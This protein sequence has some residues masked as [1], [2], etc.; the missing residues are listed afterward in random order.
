MLCE[1]LPKYRKHLKDDYH[2]NNTSISAHV[3]I[4]KLLCNKML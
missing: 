4:D 1:R 2:V 3:T